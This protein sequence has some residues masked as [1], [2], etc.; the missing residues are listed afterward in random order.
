MSPDAL[1]PVELS[2]AADASGTGTDLPDGWAWATL[3]DVA[4][5]NPPTDFGHLVADEEI[6]FVP[7]AAV[8]QETGEI[9][10]SQRRR[11]DAVRK[12]YV[13]FCDGDVIFA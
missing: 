8:A 12:G 1:T 10:A 13:R 11:V 3:N 6:P 2:G 4:A 7:M 9:A 5:I